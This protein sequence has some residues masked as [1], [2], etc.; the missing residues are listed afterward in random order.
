M[1]GVHLQ[2][3]SDILL[4]TTLLT[5]LKLRHLLLVALDHSRKVAFKSDVLELH[6]G[7][8]LFFK[9]S[10]LILLALPD[11]LGFCILTLN[12]LLQ[13]RKVSNGME[14]ILS[15]VPVPENAHDVTA[16]WSSNDSS[17]YGLRTGSAQTNEL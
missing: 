4:F 17:S 3:R 16:A 12:E 5:H 8:E 14:I 1:H 10:E 13:Q 7:L 11:R 9:C 2:D 15:N 6:L